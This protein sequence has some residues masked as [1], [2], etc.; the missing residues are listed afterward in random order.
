MTSPLSIDDIWAKSARH[1]RARGETLNEHTGRVVRRLA[2][3]RRRSPHFS[4]LPG[5]E[6][7]WHRLFWS[8]VFMTWAKRPSHFRPTYA[9][10]HPSGSTAT[11]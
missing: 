2:E 5:N 6:R 3:L 1:G 4:S 10:R 9:I 7:L 11:R 8:C